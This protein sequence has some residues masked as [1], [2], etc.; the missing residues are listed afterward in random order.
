MAT[1]E[2]AHTTPLIVFNYNLEDAPKGQK[3]QLL[4]AGGS[5]MYGV[6]LKIDIARQMGIIGWAPVPKRDKMKEIELGY[7]MPLR[8]PRP[9]KQNKDKQRSLSSMHQLEVDAKRAAQISRLL[10]FLSGFFLALFIGVLAFL[11]DR[12]IAAQTGVVSLVLFACAWY[13]RI[14][15][16][17]KE[18]LFQ[19]VR[20]QHFYDYGQ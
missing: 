12:K 7:L 4:N 6:I 8:Q 11:G 14:V 19:K 13:W 16:Q 17:C 9:P 15:C 3:V 2:A 18:E 20:E 5:A 1:N 10:G